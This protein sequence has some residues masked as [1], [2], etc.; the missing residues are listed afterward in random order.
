MIQS[1]K[2]RKQRKFRFT[3]PL[4]ERQH[5]VHAHVDKQLREKLKI[6]KRTVQISKGD[7]VKII[8]GVKKGVTG[9]VVKVDLKKVKVF[10][11]SATRKNAKGKESNIPINISNVYI[12]DLNLG[13]KFRVAKLNVSKTVLE[14]ETKKSNDAKSAAGAVA[15]EPA[16]ESTKT[17]KE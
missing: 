15:I 9:K 5:F 17:A 10:I 6:K 12:T 8:K 2:P 7:T 14:A 4:H 16:S 11:D 13:D 3:A 1:S